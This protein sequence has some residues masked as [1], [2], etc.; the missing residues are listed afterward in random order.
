MLILL[1][2]LLLL[3]G[4]FVVAE[5]AAVKIRGTQIEVMRLKRPREAALMNHIHEHLDLYLS[6]C[7]LGIT[8]T[9]IGLGFVGEPS[10]ARLL[11]PLFGGTATAHAV[12]IA[13]SYVLVSFLHIVVSELVPKSVA[14]RYPEQ[15]ALLTA[16]P[17][18]LFRRFFHLPLVVLNGSANLILRLLRLNR[19]PTEAAASEAELRVILDK[20]QQEGLMPLRRLLL[21]ENVFDFGGVKVRDEMR[22]IE[23]VTWLHVDRPWT[24]N[25][26][27]ILS[28]TFSRYPLFE[29]DPQRPLGIVHLKD[30]LYKDTPWPEPVD[31]RTIARKTFV[32]APDLP[33]EQLLT[34]LRKRRVHMALVQE[35]G[36]KVVGMITLED[37]LEQL[38]GA[39]EDEFERDTS[40]RLSDCLREDR[41]VLDLR[42][43]EPMAAITELI[44]RAGTADLGITDAQLAESVLARERTL[45]TYLGQ[46]VSVPHARLES[47]KAPCVLAGRSEKGVFFGPNPGDR[48]HVM[49]VLLTPAAT[50][51]AQV[52]LLA[53]I[54]SL[55]ESDIVWDRVREAPTA[56]SLLEA[57]RGGEELAIG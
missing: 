3:N 45:P 20:S 36:G 6:V 21:I 35:A 49:F 30:L 56:A 39:I 18:H 31:L 10:I 8:F 7:Q 29:G 11:E 41:V 50:P 34:E 51:R 26:D 15:S 24:E 38:V 27:K 13:I 16:R 44:Q 55:R 14:I 28:T 43:T 40:L 22:P 2:V 9:S 19:V 54:A 25:R 4:L 5:F 32:A 53:R 57:I 52:R 1:V 47:L 17:L 23:Q 42:A 46:G 33:L 12:A 37:I 48:A